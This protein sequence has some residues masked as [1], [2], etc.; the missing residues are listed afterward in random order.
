MPALSTEQ[1]FLWAPPPTAAATALQELNISRHKRPTL[2]HLFVCPRLFTHK[3]RKQLFKLADVVFEVPAGCRSCWPMSAH[4][5]VLIG[6]LLPFSPTPPWQHRQTQRVL[7]LAGQLR[8]VWKS[9][10]LD[11]R[12]ILREF[13]AFS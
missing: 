4:E 5:P 13:F 10:V 1:W 12:S 2:G 11:E 9:P 8:S 7:E 3:W 6:L